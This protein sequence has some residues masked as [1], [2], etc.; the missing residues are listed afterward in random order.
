MSYAYEPSPKPS[1]WI[2]L[3]EKEQIEWYNGYIKAIKDM[4]MYGRASE[5]GLS[6]LKISL[7]EARRDLIILSGEYE[8]NYKEDEEE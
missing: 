6:Q 4:M 1:W 8:R 3:T 7:D 2:E 5:Y